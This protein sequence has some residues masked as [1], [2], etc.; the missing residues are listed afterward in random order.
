MGLSRNKVAVSE[1][2][3]GSP[4]FYGDQETESAGRSR[5]LVVELGKNLGRDVYSFCMDRICCSIVRLQSESER[6]NPRGKN[7]SKARPFHFSLLTLHC[8][9][10]VAQLGEHLPCKQGV[11]GS[12]PI[13]S[14]IFQDRAFG[15]GLKNRVDDGQSKPISRASLENKVRIPFFTSQMVEER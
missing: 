5:D 8:Y 10:G 14:T 11:M 2:A 6:T 4:P 9:G 7:E 15:S 13:I 12:N 3:A 1:G